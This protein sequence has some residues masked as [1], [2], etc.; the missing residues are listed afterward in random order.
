MQPDQ[1]VE[2][3]RALR[4]AADTLVARQ[5]IRDLETTLGRI[6]FAAVETVPGADAGGISITESG[7]VGSRVPTGP[8][9][10]KLDQLQSTLAEGP[11]ITAVVE[12]PDNGVVHAGDLASAPDSD[13]W[14]NFAPQA[15]GQGYRSILSTQLSTEGGMRAALNLYSR[16]PHVFDESAQTLAGLFS[17]QAALL[18]YGAEHAA[19]M[20][21]A[22]GTRDMIGQAKGILMERFDVDDDRAFQ[23]LVRASQDTNVKLADVARWLTS[24]EGRRGA[25][26]G[27]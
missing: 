8:D 19:Q 22:L 24:P 10:G 9:V 4:N 15:A 27:E 18:L 5:S 1:N 7:H 23:M 20:E 12:P 13:R 6:V 25:E 11:C 3:L 14:P 21:K 16:E 17:V 26:Q 2:L